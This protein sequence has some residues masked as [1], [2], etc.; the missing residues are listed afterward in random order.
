M[1]DVFDAAWREHPA[2]HDTPVDATLASLLDIRGLGVLDDPTALRAALLRA[3]PDAPRHVA[4][5]IAALN[6]DVPARLVAARDD[7]TLPTLLRESVQTLQ[8]QAG[9]DAEWATWAIRT[10]AHA[11]ALPTSGLVGGQDAHAALPVPAPRSRPSTV[12]SGAGTIGALWDRAPEPPG[13]P[14]AR[15]ARAM[16]S[17]RRVRS[18]GSRRPRRSLSG[19][20]RRARSSSS[21][22]CPH[23]PTIR[24]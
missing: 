3:C 8:Q 22:R 2:S 23:R 7:A 17:S 10:W 14:P 15:C 13:T 5:V 1:E 4:A 24:S 12:Q 11:F 18:R 6:A 16:P 20:A 21:P 19:A 9:L